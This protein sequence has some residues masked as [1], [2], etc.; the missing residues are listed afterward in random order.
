MYVTKW[1][2]QLKTCD[3]DRTTENS[4][5]SRS[6]PLAGEVIVGREPDCFIVFDVSLYPMVSRRHFKIVA[7]E[8]DSEITWQISDLN[9]ANGTYVNGQRLQDLQILQSGD[10]IMLSKDGP[11]FLFECEVVSVSIP[12]EA[13]SA[14]ISEPLQT[15]QT[16][17]EISA[18]SPQLY[19]DP[20]V[21]VE[22]LT[23][24]V[25]TP[26]T[27]VGHNT[28]RSWWDLASEDNITILSGHEDLVRS[29]AFSA[30]G[31]YLTSGS[32]DKTIKIW[33]LISKKETQTLAG[34]KLAVSA[35][36]F[37]ANDKLLASGS[38]DKTIKIWDLTTGES[39]QQLT[40]HGM[41][42]NAVIFSADDKLLASGS[43]DKTIKI[44]DLTTGEVLQTFAGH[45]MGVNAVAFSPDRRLVASG[46]ADRMVK[47]WQVE[48]GA[49][50]STLPAFRSSINGLFFSPDGEI[51]AISTDD[52]TIRLWNL[53]Q[54]QEV[55]V[56]SGYSWQT[57]SLAIALDGQ[58][59]ACGSD[60]KT[61]KVW[62]L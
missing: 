42:V 21:S 45:K 14:V 34:H 57:G 48:S 25:V 9:S 27:K 18:I 58:M 8:N 3:P 17:E 50:L 32:A 52:K 28:S 4:T 60:D 24:P 10:R 54:E 38:A 23:Q 62:Q 43:A 20:I 11:E 51:L 41:G 56:L 59:F 46:S 30:D 37:S 26:I 40:G 16:D 49:E 35:V 44:W 1:S 36:A 31:Q 5:N 12:T 61:V 2:A 19:P 53:K 22:P 13:R 39:T 6:L 7:I 15:S 55:R 33:D 29:V 47:L